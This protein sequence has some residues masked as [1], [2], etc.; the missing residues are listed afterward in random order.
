MNLRSAIE[1][2]VVGVVLLLAGSLLVGQFLGQPVVVGYVETG[3]MSPTLKPGDGFIAVPM[4]LDSSIEQGDVIVFHAET[5][6]GGGLT[7][8]RVVG[9]TAEGFITRGDANPVTDQASGEPP[10]TRDQI[11]ATALQVNGH[12]VVIPNLGTLVT[13]AN[14]VLQWVQRQLAIV[15]GSRVFLGTQGLAILLF[16]VGVLS[17]VV[18]EFRQSHGRQTKRRP[19]R[20]TGILDARLVVVSLTALLVVMFTIGMVAPSTTQTFDFVSSQN[21]AP[22]PNVIEAG[23]NESVTYVVPSNGMLPAVTYLEP[24]TGNLEVSPRRLYVPANSRAN[25][26]ITIMAPAEIGTTEARLSER[27]YIAILPVGVIDWL[28]DLHPWAPILAIDAFVAI[29]FASIA[30]VVI[31]WGPIR[32]DASSPGSLV[33][34]LRR[35]FR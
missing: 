32:I 26:T 21:D 16:A 22:G 13:G 10:V 20:Q 14:G 8:H 23:T 1:Y 33:A 9:Q 30:S 34:R 3:S 17:Y 6:H 4:F 25:A 35:W 24:T 15:T 5:L 28:H 7:T 11:V 27:R 12:V 2:V 19:S 29:G 31:G 18:S